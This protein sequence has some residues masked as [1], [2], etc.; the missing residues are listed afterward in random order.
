MLEGEAALRPVK[1]AEDARKRLWRRRSGVVSMGSRRSLA[2]HLSRQPLASSHLPKQVDKLFCEHQLHTALYPSKHISTP[3]SLPSH[4]PP[5]NKQPIQWR[6]RYVAL[7]LHPP[8]RSHRRDAPLAL[9]PRAR[10]RLSTNANMTAPNS[11]RG[12]R[13][14][15]SPSHDRLIDVATARLSSPGS[16]NRLS[17]TMVSAGV[18][19]VRP[20]MLTVLLTEMVTYMKV[21][22]QPPSHSHTLPALTY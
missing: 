9:N 17:A 21:S 18:P 12:K 4:A 13:H 5:H 8:R 7:Y 11:A 14:G 20:R 2:L 19:K 16:A 10:R 15:L 3:P 1:Q 6:T 22:R